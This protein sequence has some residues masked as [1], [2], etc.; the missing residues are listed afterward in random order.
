MKLAV[1]RRLGLVTGIVLGAVAIAA[2]CAPGCEHLHAAGPM[3]VGHA[4]VACDGCHREAPGTV[5]QQLQAVARTWA[6]MR[7]GPID[8]GFQDVA[9][10]QCTACHDR[11]KDR[12]PGFRFLEP[13][14]NDVRAELHPERCESC[15]REHAG[16]RIT[17]PETTYCRHC[18]GELVVDKDPLDVPH[19]RLVAD[20]RWETCLGCHDFHGNHAGKPP[21][22]LD[23]ALPV[24]DIERYF[25]GGPSPYGEPVVRAIQPE[26]K[27]R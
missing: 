7:D 24:E 1:R 3:N 10:E 18:H 13:R 25:R 26:E 5:R 15:H 2:L 9:S 8:V 12:H 19:V 27:P 14:F 17:I 21:R 23:D 20:Q 11:P 16:V 4:T 22:R 6:G